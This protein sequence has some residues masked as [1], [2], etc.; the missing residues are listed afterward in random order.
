[1]VDIAALIRGLPVSGLEQNPV[2]Y[3]RGIVGTPGDRAWLDSITLLEPPAGRHIPYIEPSSALE[4]LLCREGSRHTDVRAIAG[5]L[6]TRMRAEIADEC[7]VTF[8]DDCEP[9]SS[10]CLPVPDF[11]MWVRREL[12]RLEQGT[13]ALQSDMRPSRDSAN[14]AL[15]VPSEML[16]FLEQAAQATRVVPMFYSPGNSGVIWSLDDMPA[17]PSS[18]GM[19]EF[20]PCGPWTEIE[21]LNIRKP[22]DN[23]FLQWRESMRPV[24]CELEKEL[25]EP[26]Y[27]FADLDDDFDDDFV[28]RFLALHWCC[29]YK[30]ESAFVRYL[31]R[32]SGVETIGALKGALIDPAS[33]KRE[34]FH[35]NKAFSQLETLPCRFEYLPPGLQKTVVVLFST[36]QAREV[37]EA[38]LAQK[39]NTNVFVVAPQELFTS[40]WIEQAMCYCRYQGGYYLHENT[41]DSPLEILVHADEL[42]V[43]ADGPS[44]RE[45]SDLRL[46]HG[47]QDLLQ[48]AYE[49]GI[50]AR[51]M[52][53]GH[54]ELVNPQGALERS[55][56]PERVAAAKAKRATYTRQLDALHLY[57]DYGASGLW[58]V[59]GML[60]YDR[61][62]LP[63]A[64]LKRVAAWQRDFDVNERPYDETGSASNEWWERHDLEA[65]DIAKALQAAVPHGTI[66]KLCRLEGWTSIEQIL[67]TETG[68][69]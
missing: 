10:E 69:P 36:L 28:H 53:A 1:M 21:G 41:L 45:G 32:L 60:P 48:L 65:I 25:G 47:A 6:V 30:P 51:Y 52:T 7:W 16:D 50:E 2:A 49:L 14:E 13:A 54:M 20:M 31:L 38:I 55:G 33:Y 59:G 46:S 5:T 17:L 35:M 42:Y 44:P 43:I 37:A 19:I 63:L 61:L 26:V 9:D 29:T 4:K 57:N 18:K 3:I 64:L 27:Y 22:D 62:D 40:P 15:S 56:A 68:L 39:I 12:G 24:A 23:P 66:V 8:F 67:R 11:L 34:R 58:T